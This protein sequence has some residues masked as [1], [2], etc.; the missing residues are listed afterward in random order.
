MSSAPALLSIEQLS[1]SLSARPILQDV[2]LQLQEGELLWLTGVNGAGKSTL[3]RAV[4]GLVPFSGSVS[5]QG[6]APRSSQGKARFTFVPDDSVLYEDLTVREH[7]T[8]TALAYGMADVERRVLSWLDRFQLTRFLDE[9]PVGHSRGMRQKLSLSLA[10][11][12]ELPLLMLDEP[13]NGLDGA[14]QAVLT[15]ALRVATQRGGAVLL[16][17]HQGDVGGELLRG[18]HASR[19]ANVVNGKLVEEDAGVPAEAARPL[20]RRS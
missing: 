16:S 4:A 9:F 3:L 13:Y 20:V 2:H 7:A 6:H 11:G 10:L 8:F 17:A 15:D 12:L 1:V 19:T 5:V 14:S 18:I